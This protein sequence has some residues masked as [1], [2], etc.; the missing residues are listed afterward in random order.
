MELGVRGWGKGVELGVRG[1]G[2]GVELG[3]WWME[4][5]SWVWSYG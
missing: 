4:W 1:W 3:M 5:R 2:K